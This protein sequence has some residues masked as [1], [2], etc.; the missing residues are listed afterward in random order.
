MIDINQLPSIDRL[1]DVDARFKAFA[2]PGAGKTT[3]LISHVKNVL[4]S[5]NKLGI[6]RRIACITYTNVAAEELQKRMDCDKSQIEVCTIHSF[7][8]N[9]VIKPFAHLIRTDE[10]GDELFNIAELQGHEEHIPHAD[11]IR[12]WLAT[13]EQR[14]QK[15]VNYYGYLNSRD[16]KSNLVKY[17][18][19]LDYRLDQVGHIDLYCKR[20][21]DL[22]IP[23]TNNELWVYKKKYWS[24]GIMHHE[25]V[26]YFAHYII[27]KSPRVL[28]FIRNR[29]PYI[30]IDEFQDTTALQTSIVQQIADGDVTIGIIGDLAQSIYKFAGAVRT[31]F[32][33]LQIRQMSA[34][35]LEQNF[36]SSQTIIDYLNTLRSDI[37]QLGYEDTLPGSVV[38]MLVGPHSQSYRW[39]LQNVSPDTVAIAPEHRDVESIKAAVAVEGEDQVKKMFAE[40]S[41]S[42]RARFIQVLLTGYRWLERKNNR[43]GIKVISHQ[44]KTLNAQASQFSIQKAG[45]FILEELKKEA[46]RRLSL[47][48]FY[49]QTNTALQTGFQFKTHSRLAAGAAQAF[50]RNCSVE[51]M[52]P[53]IKVDTQSTE[54][55]RT[56]HSAKGAEFD[57]VLVCMQSE[58][59]VERYILDAKIKL[60]APGDDGRVYYVGFSRAKTSLV[61]S[62][63]DIND[64]LIPRLNAQGIAV[65]RLVN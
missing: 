60:E 28:E 17:L 63:P 29:Y 26:L 64:N 56:I 52:L 34:Y 58:G 47:H 36:R 31:D 44:L 46:S 10:N 1:P 16:N 35:K 8:Y 19:A 12:R 5:S 39:M 2:G 62:V 27:V 48:D 37:Q 23:R 42:K 11:P 7:L 21:T 22:A 13:I 18:S 51:A 25:D 33:D 24:D 15:R 49:L 50:Y 53:F 20:H 61:I 45:I 55:V 43:Q 3:W 65:Q 38:R 40:D 41:N 30:F 14:N 6:T 59:D 32:E 4:K 9:N 57:H 54:K